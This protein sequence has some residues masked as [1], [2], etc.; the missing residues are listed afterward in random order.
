VFVSHRWGG[1]D[2]LDPSG[3]QLE[4]LKRVVVLKVL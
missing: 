1:V 4:R 3:G 2:D